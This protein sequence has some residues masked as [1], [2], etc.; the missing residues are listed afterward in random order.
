MRLLERLLAK[1]FCKTTSFKSLYHMGEGHG[2]M[3]LMWSQRTLWELVLLPP[4]GS[5][6]TELR[7]PGLVADASAHCTFSPAPDSLSGYFISFLLL[8]VSPKPFAP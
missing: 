4:C 5:R 6:G 1:E 8:W 3:M 7:S 2:A